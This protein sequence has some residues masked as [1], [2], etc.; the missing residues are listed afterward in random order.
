MGGGSWDFFLK[1]SL[2]IEEIFQRGRAKPPS[3][4][5]PIQKFIKN[6]IQQKV[7]L[8]SS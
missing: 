4:Y 6:L 5:A 7:P 2:Q 1:K 3:G 8:N